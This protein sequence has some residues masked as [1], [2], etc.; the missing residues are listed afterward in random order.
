[1]PCCYCE[2]SILSSFFFVFLLIPLSHRNLR[3]LLLSGNR[4]DQIKTL[5]QH[6]EWSL[7]VVD[8]FIP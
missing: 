4:C 3:L 8:Y 7:F 1:M 2:F 5:S 6:A